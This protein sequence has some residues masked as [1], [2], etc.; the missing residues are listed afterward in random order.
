MGKIIIL[1]GNKIMAQI[2]V[3]CDI[4]GC[5]L[6]CIIK[7]QIYDTIEEYD[8]IFDDREGEEEGMSDEVLDAIFEAIASKCSCFVQL[9]ED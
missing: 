9:K 1:K 5:Q 3:S 2:K 4:C 7:R 6:L 8:Y